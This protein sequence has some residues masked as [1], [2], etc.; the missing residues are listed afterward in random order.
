MLPF[1]QII[2]IFF[3]QL[4]FSQQK[5]QK[6]FVYLDEIIPNIVFDLRYG[7]EDNFTG[8]IVK[9]YENARPISTIEMGKALRKVQF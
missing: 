4:S 6:G 5:L 2:L 9:G 7:S 3:F 8:E 1:H